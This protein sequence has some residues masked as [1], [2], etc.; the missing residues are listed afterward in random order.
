[1]APPKLSKQTKS[2]AMRFRVD[3]VTYVVDRDELTPRI[4]RELFTQTSLTVQKAVEAVVGGASFGL[5]AL[6]FLARR[7]AG[8]AV[9]YQT[10]ED[11]LWK[12]MKAAG[13]EFDIDLIVG[14]RAGRV[15]SAPRSE[16]SASGGVAGAG[17]LVRDP[18]VGG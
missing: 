13:D 4:E 5:A 3:G 1:M 16:A 2:N 18:A 12:A 6:I 14:A 15:R 8:E 17:A 11:D 9:A 10:I 7:Q